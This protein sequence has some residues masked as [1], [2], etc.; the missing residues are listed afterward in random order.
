MFPT[1][2]SF[3][4]GLYAG[5]LIALGFGLYLYQ[6]WTPEKQVRLHS[7]HLMEAL[8]EK[9]WADA[10]EFLADAYADQWGHDRVL[11]LTRLRQI[12]P[13][14]RNLRLEAREIIVHAD[15]GEGEWRARVT[16]EADANEVSDFIKARVNLL[17][18]PFVLKWRQVSKKPWDWKLVHASNVALEIPR[19]GF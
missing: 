12:L 4:N 9:D 17:P 10:D 14:A 19:S 18:D 13:Y 2:P 1:N 6:L 11:L 15:A 5:L 7:A 8:E 16:V 3:R